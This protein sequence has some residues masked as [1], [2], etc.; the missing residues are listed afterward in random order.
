MTSP[1]Y[2]QASND[3]FS[4]LMPVDASWLPMPLHHQSV[5][6][7]HEDLRLGLDL[8]ICSELACCHRC[9][10]QLSQS[11]YTALLLLLGSFSQDRDLL[12]QVPALHEHTA[13][14]RGGLHMLS[15]DFDQNPQ[16]GCWRK[17]RGQSRSNSLF[18]SA[19][20]LL[21]DGQID[22]LFARV[23]EI[24]GSPREASFCHQILNRRR[25]VPFPGKT[26]HRCV[27]DL[28]TP[29][30]L[31][32]CTRLWHP[33]SLPMFCERAK[34]PFLFHPILCRWHASLARSPGLAS[35]EKKDRSE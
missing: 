31:G 15:V 34:Q 6:D 13:G 24:E 33:V 10:Q 20:P 27:Q 26:T 23:V 18:Q 30:V 8:D 19:A 3:F 7:G 21:R 17:V 22:G 1:F 4:N 14:I 11:C 35:H 12:A 29:C 5:Q 16:D 32:C 9:T 2:L 28:C 25:I